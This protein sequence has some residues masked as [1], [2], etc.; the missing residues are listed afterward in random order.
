MATFPTPDRAVAAALRMREAMRALNAEHGR[1]D[2]LLKIGIH[3]GPCLAV[4][5]NDRQDF[6]GQT[7]N[8]ASRVQG[9][10]QSRAIFATGSVVDH[11]GSAGSPV[12]E[13][14][15]PGAAAASLARHPGGIRGLRDPLSRLSSAAGVF[16]FQGGRCWRRPPIPP[17]PT[18]A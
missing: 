9:L 14:P 17:H 5:L 12:R 11:P 6:F 2:L 4:V 1:E 3:E 7:V 13:R 15:R 8:I 18:R 10:A 16:S